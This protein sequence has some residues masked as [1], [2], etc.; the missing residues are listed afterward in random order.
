MQGIQVLGVYNALDCHSVQ[1]LHGAIFGSLSPWLEGVLLA[2][3]ESAAVQSVP[4]VL[5]TAQHN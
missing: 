5:C 3:G 4:V 1:G 2:F